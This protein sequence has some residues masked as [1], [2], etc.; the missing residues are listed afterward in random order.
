MPNAVVHFEII[1][2]HPESLRSFYNRLFGWEYDLSGKVSDTVSEPENYGFISPL[3]DIGVAGGVGGGEAFSPQTLFYVGV[4]NV[5]E[6]LA[7]AEQLGGNRIIGPTSNPAGTLVIGRF[8]DPEGNL[9]GV[10]GNE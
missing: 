3:S 6:A 10:A 8:K 2:S 4:E 1:G 5:E 9:I 7:L